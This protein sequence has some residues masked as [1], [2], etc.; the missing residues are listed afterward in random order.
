MFLYQFA[1]NNFPETR[2]LF[3]ELWDSQLLK[4]AIR[5]EVTTIEQNIVKMADEFTAIDLFCRRLNDDFHPGDTEGFRKY[6][7]EFQEKQSSDMMNL[8]VKIQNAAAICRRVAKFYS[9]DLEEG[10]PE[11]LF[12]VIERFVAMLQNAKR[13]LLKLEKERLKAERKAA[14]KRAKEQKKKDKEANNDGLSVAQR[15]ENKKQKAIEEMERGD[16]HSALMN[17]IKS[18]AG[19][20]RNRQQQMDELLKD[21]TNHMGPGFDY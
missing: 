11:H 6:M 5:L 2:E 3:E 13:S 19:D 10:K 9:I 20:F 8:K 18:A 4:R 7:S 15:I 17:A 1:Y 12:V 16:D 21:D 14:A